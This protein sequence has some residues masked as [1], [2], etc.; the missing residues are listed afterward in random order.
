MATTAATFQTSANLLWS[1]D[2]WS[3][4]L[5][6]ALGIVDSDSMIADS[7][8]SGALNLFGLNCFGTRYRLAVLVVTNGYSV[9]VC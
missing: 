8:L 9:A 6:D 7:I 1:T 2:A 4:L 3:I 5:I